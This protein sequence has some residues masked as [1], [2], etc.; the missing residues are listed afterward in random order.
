MARRKLARRLGVALGFLFVGVVSLLAFV[1]VALNTAWG[2]EQLRRQLNTSLASLFQGR[3]ELERIGAVGLFGVSGVD[4]SVYDP[5]GQRVLQVR[6]LRAL[7]SLP[8]LA[9]QLVLNADAPELEIL[10]VQVDHAEVTLR[11]DEDAGVT[12]ATT[13]LPREESEP[14]AAPDSEGGPHLRIRHIAFSHVWAHGQVQG[15]PPLDA[16]L[17][18]LLASL[19][20]SPRDG[21]ELELERAELVT[22]GMPLAAEP[23]G[24]VS[25]SIEVPPDESRPMR[26]E[27]FVEG[28]A[29]GSPL[30]L[31][32]SWVGDEL[33][34]SVSLLRLPAEHLNRELPGLALDGVVTVMAEVDGALPELS[35]WLEADATA[36]HVTASGEIALSP[37]LEATADV[38]VA[39]FDAGRLVAGAPQSGLDAAVSAQLWEQDDAQFVGAY[40]VDVDS[41]GVAGE[42]TPRVWLAGEIALGEPE[43]VATSGR[44][45]ADERGASARGGYAVTLP[46]QGP[47]KVEGELEVELAEPQRLS[48]LGVLAAG[49]VSAKGQLGLDDGALSGRA[50]ASLRRVEVAPL[51]ARNVEL[52]ATAT[53]KSDAPRL[54]AAASLD[55]L[56]GRAHADLDYGP[57]RQHLALFAADVDLPR[58]AALL[59]VELPL[60]SGTVALDA[61]VE[62]SSRSPRFVLDG[63]AEVK[64]GKIG[65]VTVAAKGLELPSSLS[66]DGLAQLQG[67]LRAS[68]NVELAEL[69]PLLTAADVPIERTAGRVRFSLSAERSQGELELVAAVGTHGLRVVGERKSPAELGRR[70]VTGADSPASLEGVDL[71]LSLRAQ[72]SS[73]VTVG[74]LLLRDR[75]GTLAELQAE[76]Q[77][78]DFIGSGFASGA[79]LRA[80][81]R[82]RLLVTDRRLQSLPPLVRP[83]VV[84][85]RLTLEA[86]VAGSVADPRVQAMFVARGLRSPDHDQRLDLD[87]ELRCSLADGEVKVRAKEVTT[88][89]VVADTQVRWRGDLRRA[90]E[91]TDGA[92]PLQ[93]SADVKLSGFP[94]E[95]VSFLADRQVTGKLSGEVKLSDWGRDA[96]LEADLASSGLSVSRVPVSELRFKARTER[97]Q[98]VGDLSLR[99]GQQGA[100]Q[101]TLAA[102][103]R[104]GKRATPEL[105]QSGVIRVKARDFRLETLTPLL[106]GSLSE[107]AGRLDAETEVRVTPEATRVAGS[108]TLTKGVVQ[109]PAIGQRFSN[110]NAKVSVENDRFRLERL[111]ASGLTGKVTVTG[112][113]RLEGF[114]LRAADATVVIREREMLPITLEGAALGDAW[115]TVR[116]AYDSPERRERTL[117]V[118]VPQFRL[119][120]PETSGK[121]LQSLDGPQD[122]RVGVRRADGVFVP[123][124]VQPLEPGGGSDAPASDEAPLVVLVE[125]GR[126]V[127]VERGRTAQAQLTGKLRV[128]TA[129]ETRVTGRIEVRGGKLDVQ[130]KNFEIERGVVTFDGKDPANPTITATA[131]WDAPDYT[132]YA[133]YVGDVENGRIKL[134]AEPSL[135][136]DEIAS[137]L[138]FG[139]PEGSVGSGSTDEAAL[140][141]GVA[142]DTAAKGLNQVLDDFTN[143]DVSARVDTT[144]GSAR[145][146]LVMRVSPRVAAKVTRAVGTPAVGESPDR[147]FLTLELRLRRAWALSA[148]LGDRGASALDLIWRRRY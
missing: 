99:T 82:A 20:Q 146:E 92:L 147:T 122:I 11:A 136:Q 4:A 6:G 15:S 77:L 115:G 5:D 90:G 118:T 60:T 61:S 52:V 81:L 21:L 113:A 114:A 93:G 107:V 55:L 57:E 108:A 10:S 128:E 139:S 46:S 127:T 22:R 51:Q 53:G 132:V 30:S 43:G 62:R 74:T 63:T 106:G 125:L 110:I 101:A 141:V 102:G 134:R 64:A 56:S 96:R 145:P 17:T 34:A 87:G 109:V 25:G 50:T 120:T 116:V 126:D 69:S 12:L 105:T 103:M 24:T 68:G 89:G 119:V 71:H 3:L 35:F 148:V 39:G 7:A 137:L 14:A 100:T 112:G 41:G 67:D 49:R 47:G 31:G 95:V 8:G 94:L 97:E 124:P 111:E 123:L 121:G 79:L 29:A 26:L 2:R 33:H 84:R 80:P 83:A 72:P 9:R 140:A 129:P 58:L 131:R 144:T 65:Q 75:R 1:S 36:A 48:A 42:P 98:L 76:A 32:V 59:G 104:W 78:A 40:R 38:A 19:K 143:L 138:L 88:G 85:G 117:K 66:V 23:R 37:L 130:G 27:G 18:R 91:I 44:F 86:N 16:E 133:D 70:A 13:F 45:S 28:F 73:G 135:T 54:K 142:G